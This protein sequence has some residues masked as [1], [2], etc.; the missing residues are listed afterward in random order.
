MKNRQYELALTT[1]LNPS[2]KPMEGL[3]VLASVIGHDQSPEGLRA[4]WGELMQYVGEHECHLGDCVH[5]VLIGMLLVY[6]P[7]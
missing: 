1:D 3:K 7:M 5:G 4:L 6:Y 2:L